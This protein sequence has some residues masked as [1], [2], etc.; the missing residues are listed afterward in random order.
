MNV[1]YQSTRGL[2]KLVTSSYAILKGLA[3]DGGLYVPDRIPTLE[4]S[5][6]ELA[7]MSYKEV[8]Y[9]VMKLFFTDFTEAE[10]KSCI[11]KAYDEKFDT[12][13]IAPL[14]KANIP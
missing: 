8:A 9:E 14:A 10:L 4:V 12:E 11:D 2:E 7:N 13:E 1:L 6:E 3:E 5:L